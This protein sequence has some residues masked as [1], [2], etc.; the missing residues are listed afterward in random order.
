MSRQAAYIVTTPSAHMHRGEPR[1]IHEPTLFTYHQPSGFTNSRT[2]TNTHA[3]AP[4]ITTHVHVPPPTFASPRPHN[5]TR[6]V[7]QC[8]PA[9]MSTHLISIYHIII[10]DIITSIITPSQLSY[11]ARLRLSRVRPSRPQSASHTTCFPI[12]TFIGLVEYKSV[13]FVP[14]SFLR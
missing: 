12:I 3:Q 14:L 5:H 1:T 13:Y 10:I 6:T 8:T 11:I 2:C 9:Y 7:N 4:P